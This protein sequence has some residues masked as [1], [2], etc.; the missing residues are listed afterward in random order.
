MEAIKSPAKE[1]AQSK[2]SLNVKKIKLPFEALFKTINAST[3]LPILED[4]LIERKGGNICF[5]TT[6]LENISTIYMPDVGADFTCI[7]PGI[8]LKYLVKNSIAEMLD[9]ILS[10]EPAHPSIS[11][12]NSGFSLKLN[13]EPID[14]YPKLIQIEDADFFTVDVKGI[15]PYLETA[16]AYTSGDNLRPALTGV[17]FKDWNGSLYIVSTDA[18]RLYW[19]P[20]CKTPKSFKGC[21]FIISHKAVSLIIQMCKTEKSVTVLKNATHMGIVCEGKQF[22][23]RQMDCKY[24][25]FTVVIPQDNPLVFHIKRSELITHLRMCQ[26]F[27]NKST[28]QIV[29]D[30]SPDK[31]GISGG[32]FDFGLD[33]SDSLPVHNP[34][35]DTFNPFRF[36]VNVRF[37]LQAIV[38]GKDEYVKVNHSM[39]PLKAMIIDDH[40]LLMPLM[41]NE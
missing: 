8:E 34:N 39:M 10:G 2:F 13:S 12:K 32:D 41:I 19:Y 29:I 24:P 38:G 23:T 11:I 4:V 14:N 9:V 40:L 17:C 22:V 16:L 27:T 18:H 21:S 5:S 1:K 25:D 7:F 37:L 35:I 20:L 31:I 3:V 33:F 36:G 6:D 28:G 26:W 30:V 15:S